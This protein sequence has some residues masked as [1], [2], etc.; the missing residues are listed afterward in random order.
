MYILPNNYLV[1]INRESDSL[2]EIEM[3]KLKLSTSIRRLLGVMLVSSLRAVCQ[4]KNWLSMFLKKGNIKV[5]DIL[6]AGPR[7]RF[8]VDG[9]YIAS[10]CVQSGGHDVHMMFICELHWILNREGI[11]H[12]GVIWDFHDQSIVSVPEEYGEK[13]LECV[14]KARVHINELLGATIELKTTP[15]LSRDMSKA[16]EAEH[17]WEEVR[18]YLV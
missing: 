13:Y 16:K 11:P 2:G 4:F 8:A 5:Y 7:R 17:N 14:E 18:G 12:M 6:N 15:K 10:N 3:W 9:G 1:T